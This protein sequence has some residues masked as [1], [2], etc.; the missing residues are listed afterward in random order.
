MLIFI[1]TI[2]TITF[3]AVS[4][5]A[6][7]TRNNTKL[8]YEKESPF[9][10]IRVYEEEFIRT[11]CFGYDSDAGKQSRVD[12]R[13]T[14]TL[15]LEYTRLAFAGLL[16]NETPQRV[17]TIGIGGGVIPRTMRDCFPNT[18]IDVVEID[19][20]VVDVAKKYFF[21]KPDSNLRVHISDGRSF[22]K[23]EAYGN[24]AGNYDMIILDAYDEESIPDHMATREFLEHVAAILDPK[25]VVAANMLSDHRLFGSGIK[26]F[27]A[28]YGRCYVFMGKN[29]KNA[30]LLSPGPEAPDLKA[31]IAVERAAILQERHHFTFNMKEIAR[32]F[33]PRYRPSPW[34]RILTDERL[35]VSI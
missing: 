4:L 14:K 33:R 21:F 24:A 5:F 22:V 11:L 16:L 18:E 17:L 7:L 19:P 29:T 25:G 20:D 9:H 28:V 15:L 35:D 3:T 34:S 27:R 8:L 31:E 26:T 13:D 30:I 1:L 2:S 6:F 32:Q 23:R 12:L 10:H